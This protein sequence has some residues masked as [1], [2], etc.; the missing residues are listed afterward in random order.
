ME[1]NTFEGTIP[2]GE[3]GGGTVM[4]W[5]RGTYEPDEGSVDAL[6]RG[7]ER[8]D[9]KVT[10]HGE[11]LRG[12]FALVRMASRGEGKPQWLLIKHATRRRPGWDASEHDTSVTTGRTM[13]EIRE[14]SRVSGIRIGGTGARSGNGNREPRDHDG[15]RFPFPVS[16]S[17][18][19][20]PAYPMMA[21][22]G[23][24]IPTGAGWTSSPSTTACACWP[25][26]RAPALGSSRET[27]RTSRTN[28]R[29]HGRSSSARAA[30]Q[31]AVRARW[32]DRRVR[33][34]A[35]ARFQAL[36]SRMHLQGDTDIAGQCDSTPVRA[37]CVRPPR[38]WRLGAARPAMERPTQATRA[39][40]RARPP[41]GVRLG[42][43]APGDGEKL[44]ARARRDDWEGIIAKRSTRRTSQALDRATGSS[45]RS[46]SARSSSSA[47]TPSP[48]THASTSAPSSS[49]ISTAMIS[50]TWDTRAAASRARASRRWRS[51]SSASSGSHPRSP[52]RA[53]EREG[54]L[55]AARG[56][57]RVKFNEWTADGRLRQPIFLGVRDDKDPRDVT[58]EA[59]SV[60]RGS[61]AG[62]R[63]SACRGSGERQAASST[64]KKTATSA[65]RSAPSSADLE[66][67]SRA[68]GELAAAEQRGSRRTPNAGRGVTLSLSSLDKVWFPAA[69]VAT[70]RV[71]CC[72]TTCA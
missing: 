60:Q 19:S 55:G 8:G 65:Q 21:S 44:L 12:S 9:I 71:T 11:R 39:V 70:R 69:R 38:G 53:D 58:R 22:I 45:S 36:Q 61:R 48:A 2:A 46:S 54:P 41:K 52:H 4:L 1:Y 49:A 59:T 14:G 6:R 37:H 35:P 27:A 43:S 67:R 68:R 10:F 23:T 24:S 15:S 47:A 34:D 28:S 40:H 18:S 56:R 13:D 51:D 5:D 63:P 30:T 29:G 16:R 64:R 66:N 25:S 42:D 17:R 31:A 62:A 72:G 57:G 32:R 7:F 3:Y 33:G 26:R 20:R 50:S